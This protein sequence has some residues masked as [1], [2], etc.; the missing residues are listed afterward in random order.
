MFKSKINRYLNVFY[1]KLT[2]TIISKYIHI[3]EKRIKMNVPDMNV[4]GK[5]SNVLVL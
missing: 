4:P 2:Q 3:E 1:Q 5:Y